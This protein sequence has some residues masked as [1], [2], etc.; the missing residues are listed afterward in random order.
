MTEHHW[1]EPMPWQDEQQK[2]DRAVRKMLRDAEIPVPA[3]DDTDPTGAPVAWA[4]GVI[5]IGFGFLLG[6]TAATFFGVPS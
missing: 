4:V 5:L 2:Q 6:L 3:D 1:S